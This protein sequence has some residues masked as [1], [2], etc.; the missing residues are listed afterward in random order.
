MQEE[1]AKQEFAERGW[2]HRFADSFPVWLTHRNSGHP[3]FEN[4]KIWVSRFLYILNGNCLAKLKHQNRKDR[5]DR[6]EKLLRGLYGL[7]GSNSNSR[8]LFRTRFTDG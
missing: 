4:S 3:L 8:A 2:N 5:E 6:K 7:R 1:K